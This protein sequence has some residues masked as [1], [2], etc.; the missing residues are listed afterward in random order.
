MTKFSFVDIQ[1]RRYIRDKEP[2]ECPICHS[3]I[4]PDELD[5]RLTVIDEKPS[6]GL[7]IVYQCPRRECRHL[8][9][10]RYLR[11]DVGVP[12]TSLAGI[13]PGL[14]EFILQELVPN[15]PHT[16]HIP[17]EISTLSPLFPEIYAQS[18]AAESYGLAQIAG[19]GYRKALEFLVKDYCISRNKSAEN[20]IKSSQLANCINKYIDSP[21][22]KLCAERAAWLGNDEIHYVRKW[23]DKDISNLKELIVLTINWIHSSIITQKYADDMSKNSG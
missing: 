21:Q 13:S 20:E 22:V 17:E 23:T 15:T 6:Y 1:Q 10:A 12:N 18:R 8:F 3:Y 5:W 7:E 9:I 14:R 16:S 2:N 11:S 4:Q 19:G